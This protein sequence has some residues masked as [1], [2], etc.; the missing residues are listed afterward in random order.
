M[1][2]RRTELG[3]MRYCCSDETMPSLQVSFKCTDFLADQVLLGGFAA[4]GLSQVTSMLEHLNPGPP[5]EGFP[6]PSPAI[7]LLKA[8]HMDHAE[9]HLSCQ[10]AQ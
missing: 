5:C 2:H 10:Q 4:G 7:A 6:D 9:S 8:P 3:A 1:S